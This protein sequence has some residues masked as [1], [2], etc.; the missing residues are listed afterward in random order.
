MGRYGGRPSPQPA[1]GECGHRRQPVKPMH[2]GRDYLLLC[3][4]RRCGHEAEAL[5]ERDAST[6]RRA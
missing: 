6:R 5:A 2:Q 4:C 1:L 3:V